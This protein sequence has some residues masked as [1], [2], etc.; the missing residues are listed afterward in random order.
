M[1]SITTHNSGL[2][3]KLSALKGLIQLVPSVQ[4]GL[5]TRSCRSVE[6]LSNNSGNRQCID[7][8]FALAEMKCALIHALRKYEFAVDTEKT[9]EPFKLEFMAASSVVSISTSKSAN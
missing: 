2:T 1:N 8:K 9:K 6:V 4:S 3:P 5:K 7:L